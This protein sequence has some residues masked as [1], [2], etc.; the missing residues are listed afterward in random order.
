MAIDHPRIISLIMP[1]QIQVDAQ[2][3]R[4]FLTGYVTKTE[5][6]ELT[7]ETALLDAKFGKAFDRLTDL[8]AMEKSD[9]DYETISALGKE[10]QARTFQNKF[11]SAIV[12]PNTLDYGC[13]RMFQ[14]LSQNPQVDRQ[15]FKTMVE[16]ELWLASSA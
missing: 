2:I 1:F 11:R 4:I 9:S 15:I 13:A 5:M 8:S 14:T 6:S 16:A 7:G 3:I 10:R 12:A